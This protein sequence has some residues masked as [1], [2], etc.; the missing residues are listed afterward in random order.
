MAVK[1]KSAKKAQI[2]K[3]K[4]KK[5]PGQPKQVKTIHEWLD[6]VRDH[7]VAKEAID[8][9]KGACLL[10]DPNGGPNFCVQVTQST[11]ATLKGTWLDGNC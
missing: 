1:K 11:C 7:A 10:P 9:H 5:K 2:K 8:E 4:G 3:D 6:A